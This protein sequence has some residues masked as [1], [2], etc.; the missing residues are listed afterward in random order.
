LLPSDGFFNDANGTIFWKGRYHVFYL[1]RMPL[2]IPDQPGNIQWLPVFDHSSSHDLVHW[3]QHPPAIKPAADGSTPKGIYSG[4]AIEN[5]PIPTLIYH[6]PGQGICI[7]TSTDD[8]LNHWTPLPENPV[9]PIPQQSQEYTVFDPC[10]WYED[11]IYHALIGNKNS[12]QGYEGDTTSLFISTDLINWQYRGP[13]YKSNRHWT[14]EVEDCACP[15]FFPLGDR[16]ML[17]MH[18]HCP[19]GMAHYYLGHYREEQFFP[20]I[21]G[22][23]NWPGGQLS[24]PETLLDD[25][26]R[27]IFFGWIRETRPW[28]QLRSSGWA[29]VMT[30][31]RV[32][33]LAEDGTLGIEPVP[34]LE[35]LRRNH[36]RWPG[37][38]LTSEVVIEEVS[39]DCL[40][41]VAEFNSGTATTFG[42]KVQRSPDGAEETAIFYMPESDSLII[43]FSKSTLDKAVKYPRFTPHDEPEG[44]DDDDRY[45]SAQQAP[46]ELA[47]GERLKLRIFLDRSVLEVFANGRQCM[48][49][50][51]YPTREDS[52]GVSV[53]AYGGETTL[54]SLDV[55]EMR[56]TNSW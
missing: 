5:A 24:A 14:D 55:W 53:F 16:H 22:R 36:R 7:A 1:G 51:I 30:L 38:R 17:L 50:R 2:P 42:L 20:Q 44:V 52:L 35:T 10:A 19:Y 18:G 28:E 40:E 31:P 45:A 27:R 54:K 8:E 37:I 39:G 46:F 33:S 15:D 48:T 43:D 4:D 11:G 26:G 34:E 29:S 47:D 3:I 23:M 32:L 21:H 9:I 13:F 56:T 49:Q 12:R 25:K 41:L 6:V